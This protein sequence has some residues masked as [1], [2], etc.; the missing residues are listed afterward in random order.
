MMFASPCCPKVLPPTMD[1]VLG[2]DDPF[3]DL[4]PREIEIRRIVLNGKSAKE[5]GA[6]LHISP[7]P[8]QNI[9]YQAKATLGVTS[10]IELMRLALR[11]KLAA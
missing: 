11:L 10:D 3:R 5:I 2:G 6:V 4:W 9:H 7:K 1:E 8:A